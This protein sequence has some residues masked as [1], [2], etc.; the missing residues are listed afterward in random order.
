MHIAVFQH[1]RP[2][3]QIGLHLARHG[4]GGRLQ[5]AWGN[6]AEIK[7]LGRAAGRHH[8]REANATKAAIPGLQ[9]RQRKGR[10]HRRIRRRAAGFQNGHTCLCRAARLGRHHALAARSGRLGDVPMLG[11]MKGRG[12][13]HDAV[14]SISMGL[15]LRRPRLPASPRPVCPAAPFL[16]WNPSDST[17]GPRPAP[18]SGACQCLVQRGFSLPPF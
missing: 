12:I 13:G 17:G 9:R 5:A 14:S 6:R 3:E 2:G 7:G 4:E 11:S 1:F 10:G 15:A 16:L 8:L 18:C